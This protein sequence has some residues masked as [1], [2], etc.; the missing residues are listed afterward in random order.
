MGLLYRSARGDFN[1][2]HRAA[3]VAWPPRA[4]RARSLSKGRA[5]LSL[6]RILVRKSPGDKSAPAWLA[7]AQA[8]ASV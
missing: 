4:Q 6:A 7:A 5:R 2:T 8:A 1:D 3:D